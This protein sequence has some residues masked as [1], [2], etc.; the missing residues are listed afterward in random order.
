MRCSPWGHKE[1]DTTEQLNWTLR[2][3]RETQEF[4]VYSFVYVMWGAGKMKEAW[5]DILRCGNLNQVEVS[6]VGTFMGREKA[7]PGRRLEGICRNLGRSVSSPGWW[8]HKC[9]CHNSFSRTFMFHVLFYMY[10]IFCNK[11]LQNIYFF[12]L[13]LHFIMDHT[14]AV[15]KTYVVF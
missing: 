12:N 13:L 15:R 7:V 6:E 9:V 10:A 5:R 2:E 11:R 8:L 14:A 1:S 4:T 3:R